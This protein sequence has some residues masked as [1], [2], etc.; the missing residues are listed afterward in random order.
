MDFGALPPEVNSARMYAGPGAGPLVAA[1]AG[2]DGLA[3]SLSESA[4]ST[5][6]LLAG[7]ADVWLGRAALAMGAT[8]A[9]HVAWLSETAGMAAD[10]AAQ[11]SAA[12]SAYETAYVATVPPPAVAANRTQ[13]VSLVATNLLGQNT[14][15]ISATEAEYMEMWA[16]DSAAMLAYAAQSAQATPV[17][18]VA[19]PAGFLGTSQSLPDLVNQTLQSFLSSGPYEVPLSLL[20]VFSGLW[21]ASS[22]GSTM[23]AAAASSAGVTPVLREM[24]RPTGP[25]GISARLGV[26]GRLGPLS[27]PPSWAT[28]PGA[29]SARA[30]AAT[31]SGA[32]AAEGGA[33]PMPFGGM[34]AGS[35]RQGRQGRPEPEYGFKSKFTAIKGI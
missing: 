9:Q 13:L 23:T 24:S 31:G 17:S 11:A 18:P 15:A 25:L 27:V 14:P 35:K 2:W 10:T 16:Q 26:G 1:A 7:L 28:P 34:G 20:Q 3:A 6:A 32:A 19:S 22:I 21:G 29:S 4:A 12:A 33:F 5:S 8:V 30:I